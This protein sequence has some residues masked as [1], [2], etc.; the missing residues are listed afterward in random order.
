MADAFRLEGKTVV[1]TGAAGV[2]GTQVAQAFVEAGAR[3]CAIDRNAA[4]LTQKLRPEHSALLHCP[5]DVSD[6]GSLPLGRLAE[7][8][9]VAAAIRYLVS[10]A[11]KYVTGHNLVVDGGRTAW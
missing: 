2:I 11:S 10:D 9:D 6:R 4:L 5:A 8:S 7:V 3:V 1:L